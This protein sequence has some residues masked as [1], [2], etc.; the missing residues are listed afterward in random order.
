MSFNPTQTETSERRALTSAVLSTE[1]I[2]IRVV[3]APWGTVESQ[4]GEFVVDEES[5]AS[6]IGS[7][8]AHGTDLPI[9]YEHQTL[10]G[11]FASPDGRAPAAGWI[12]ALSFEPG[13]GIIGHIEWTR[14]GREMLATREYRYLSPVA[15]IR[16]SDRRLVGIHSAALTNKPAIVGMEAIVNREDAEPHP[17]DDE[18]VIL[19]RLREELSLSADAHCG[20]V[21]AAAHRR[22]HELNQTAR[23]AD[24]D[25]RI[26]AAQRAGK[27]TAAQTQWARA[28]I[29]KSPSLFDEWEA[30]APVVVS[31]G[32]TRPPTAAA[33][34]RR[35]A[36][37][38]LA[39]AEFRSQPALAALTTEEA[40]VAD[41]LRHG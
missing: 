24:A 1:E 21:I 32:S 2:P 41:C 31:L 12:K 39:R 35:S 9:D 8:N 30:T 28:M 26:A 23:D 20:E 37:E 29:A 4:K 3:I 34:P 7:F 36:S 16:K 13:V 14:Q 25:Q 33:A 27:L 6:V 5:A 38:A 15:L 22:L 40:Y 10:G 11:E 18:A 19:C 17:S